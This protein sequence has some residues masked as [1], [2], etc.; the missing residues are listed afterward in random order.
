MNRVRR[1]EN[2][3]FQFLGKLIGINDNKN[4][5]AYINNLQYHC[6]APE[7]QLI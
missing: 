1:R 3:S 7:I 2:G 4:T 5:P 6:S